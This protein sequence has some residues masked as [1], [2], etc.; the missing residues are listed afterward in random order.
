VLLVPVGPPWTRAMCLISLVVSRA[1]WIV[2]NSTLRERARPS[3]ADG[4]ASTQRG[5]RTSHT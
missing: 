5:L 2:A 4:V 1:A 3:G